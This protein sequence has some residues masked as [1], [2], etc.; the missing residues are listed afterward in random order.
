[1]SVVA[2]V[3]R[4]L[5]SRAPAVPSK[6]ADQ[7]VPYG[8]SISG[9]RWPAPVESCCL[10]VTENAICCSAQSALT[11]LMP[12]KSIRKL[13]IEVLA[14]GGAQCLHKLQTDTR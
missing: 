3:R 9:G 5:P 6:D 1:M 7:C 13:T 11:S 4:Q 2:T 14:A 12:L 10:D 8:P